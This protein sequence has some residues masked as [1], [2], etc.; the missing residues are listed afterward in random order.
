MGLEYLGEGAII[1]YKIAGSSLTVVNELL[2]QNVLSQQ[3][4]SASHNLENR[5]LENGGVRRRK[6][7]KKIEILGGP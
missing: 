3:I 4:K 1:I 2:K 5:K 7:K 6:K